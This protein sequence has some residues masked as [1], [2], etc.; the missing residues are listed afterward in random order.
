[1]RGV[2]TNDPFVISTQNMDDYINDWEAGQEGAGGCRQGGWG[3]GGTLGL[4]LGLPLVQRWPLQQ[5]NELQVKSPQSQSHRKP[6]APRGFK[7]ITSTCNPGKAEKSPVGHRPAPR[8]HRCGDFSPVLPALPTACRLHWGLSTP[9]RAFL[10]PFGHQVTPD[11]LQTPGPPVLRCLP[12]S[13][14]THVH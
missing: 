5:T 13:A 2:S 10:E 6:M 8:A 7:C 4:R 9:P 1:M 12:E 14:Q 3:G 11:S